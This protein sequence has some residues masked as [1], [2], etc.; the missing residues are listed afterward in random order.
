MAANLMGAARYM[1]CSSKT[2][3]GVTAVVDEGI[4]ILLDMEMSER[5]A[6]RMNYQKSHRRAGRR[7]GQLLCF[8]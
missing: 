1:E 8:S 7:V 5:E 3:E 2:G 4:R 6:D